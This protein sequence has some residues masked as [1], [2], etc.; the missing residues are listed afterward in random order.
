MINLLN[1][2]EQTTKSTTMT[3]PSSNYAS[4]GTV[5]TAIVGDGKI[6]S[7]NTVVTPSPLQKR[8]KTRIDQTNK[9]TSSSDD[10]R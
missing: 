6:N 2:I 3:D 10:G 4:L 1:S 9:D 7:S 5:E 8:Q